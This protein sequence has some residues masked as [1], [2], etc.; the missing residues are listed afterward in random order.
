MIWSLIEIFSY[1]AT[2]YIWTDTTTGSPSYLYESHKEHNKASNYKGLYGIFY[3]RDL[4]LFHDANE[5]LKS[6]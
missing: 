5:S 3:K 1:T 6:S 2:V 4:I